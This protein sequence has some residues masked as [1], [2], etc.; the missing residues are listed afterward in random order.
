MWNASHLA[1][2]LCALRR[3]KRVSMPPTTQSHNHPLTR[4]IHIA[5]RTKTTRRFHGEKP[6]ITTDLSNFQRLVFR[7]RRAVFILLTMPPTSPARAAVVMWC[8]WFKPLPQTTNQR[9]GS[10][11]LLEMYW[12]IAVCIETCQRHVPTLYCNFV[13]AMIYKFSM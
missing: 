6:L 12:Y 5:P 7:R 1:V 10:F 3:W 8:G 4:A 13:L 2:R 9:D 11:G